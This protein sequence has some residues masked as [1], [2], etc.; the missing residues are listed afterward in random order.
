MK[1]AVLA[2]S[3]TRAAAMEG[4]AEWNR[5]EAEE[6]D[7]ADR[8]AAQNADEQRAELDC[9]AGTWAAEPDGAGG[10]MDAEQA[11]AVPA[12]TQPTEVD[13]ALQVFNELAQVRLGTLRALG[14]L[15]RHQVHFTVDRSCAVSELCDASKAAI[16]FIRDLTASQYTALDDEALRAFLDESEKLG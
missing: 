4:I 16:D 12:A 9:D 8:A 15:Q 7:K 11:A 14:L 1:A 5:R 13:A 3:T 10:A 2:D 6:Q